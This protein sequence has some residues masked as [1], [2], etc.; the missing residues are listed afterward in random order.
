MSQTDVRDSLQFAARGS[1]RVITLL[2]IEPDG[3]LTW[4]E[5]RSEIRLNNF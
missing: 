5:L 2:R 1:R 4:I 3:L